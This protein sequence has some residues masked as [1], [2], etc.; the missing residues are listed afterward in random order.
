MEP[1]R[2]QNAEIDYREE[3]APKNQLYIFAMIYFA[4]KQRP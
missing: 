1:A 4:R 3:Y 2:C